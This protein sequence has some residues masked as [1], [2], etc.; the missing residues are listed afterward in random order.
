MAGPMTDAAKPPPPPETPEAAAARWFARGRSG[1]MTPPEAE[2]L[3][4]WLAED[5]AHR[6]L[7]DQSEY[8]WGAASA[9][10]GDPAIL[11]LREE[12]ARAHRDR[13]RRRWLGG[14]IAAA[15]LVTAGAG[16]SALPGM[17]LSAMWTGERQFST[18]VGQ[19]SIVKL[20]DGSIITLDTNSS[21]R[22]SVTAD[23]RVI[24]LSRGQA[25]FK[26]AKDRS[27]PFMVF[28]GDKVVTATGTAFSVRV[29]AKAVAVTLV[30]GRVRVEEAAGVRTGP[31]PARPRAAPGPIESTELKPGSRLVA[32]QDESWNVAPVDGVKAVS[33]MEGQLI[34]EDRA[35]AQVAAELNRYSDKK[36]V[37]DDP[38]LAGRPITGAFATGDV[39]AFVSALRSYRLARVVRES[40][41]E[42][43]LGPY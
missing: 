16:L 5:P 11:A 33:W 12:V 20:R 32:V 34:F 21:L 35:L 17:P 1:A 6:A 14:A 42:V 2:A 22:A 43:V 39:P 19:T 30:E 4:A 36:I 40:R 41:S 26:V 38:A 10:R 8:W 15:L 37:I 29:D 31:A 9:V 7:F 23:R 13:G 18:G 28:A 24:H 27:R 25:F 3:E